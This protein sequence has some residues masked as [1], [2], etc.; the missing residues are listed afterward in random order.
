M[1]RWVRIMLAGLACNPELMRKWA[2]G[3]E[4]R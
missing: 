3:R 2:L 4:P 1:K